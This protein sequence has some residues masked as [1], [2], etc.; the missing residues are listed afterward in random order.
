LT[1]RETHISHRVR[2]KEADY[3]KGERQKIRRDTWIERRRKKRID[4]ARE[5]TKYDEQREEGQKEGK[6]MQRQ[7]KQEGE[8]KRGKKLAERQRRRKI[9]TS[10][11]TAELGR[12]N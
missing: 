7:G 12:G 8:T 3:S 10:E 6:N 1:A 11:E 2:G 4:R 9:K 5:G